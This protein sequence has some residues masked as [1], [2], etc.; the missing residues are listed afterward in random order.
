MKLIV[1][2][3]Q[4]LFSVAIATIAEAVLVQISHTCSALFFL[5]PTGYA[6]MFLSLIKLFFHAQGHRTGSAVAVVKTS[7]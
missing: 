2:Y 1:L 5:P 4:I 6:C 3:H 7:L